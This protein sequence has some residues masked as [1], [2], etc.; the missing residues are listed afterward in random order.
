MERVIQSRDYSPDM[1]LTLDSEQRGNTT[2]TI[3]I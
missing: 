2:F 1:C 3:Q